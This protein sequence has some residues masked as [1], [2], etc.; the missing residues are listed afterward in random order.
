MGKKRVDRS[1]TGPGA[2][3]SGDSPFAAL[4]GLRDALPEGEAPTTPAEAAPGAAQAASAKA[5][6]RRERSG[7]GGKTVT[8]IE[9]LDH[10]A[11][12]LEALAKRL[13]KALGCGARVEAGAIVLQGE[14][15]ERAAAWLEAEGVA[16]RVVMATTRGKTSR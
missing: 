11:A 13:K 7:H 3:P 8:R 5:V 16:K 12:G 15:E 14:L 6:V 9:Q 1:Q 10:D 2:S 4:A